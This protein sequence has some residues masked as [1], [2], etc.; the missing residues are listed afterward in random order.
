MLRHNK[1]D[2]R[3]TAK[4]RTR[5]LKPAI[6]LKRL[7]KMTKVSTMRKFN[8]VL[9]PAMPIAVPTRSPWPISGTGPQ[10]VAIIQEKNSP[11]A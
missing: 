11:G 10:G 2:K 7:E 4:N 1:H 3:P 6:G 5:L 8:V 9:I